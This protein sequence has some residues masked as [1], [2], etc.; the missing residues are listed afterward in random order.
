VHP[1]PNPPGPGGAFTWEDAEDDMKRESIGKEKAIELANSKWW[2]GK[3][4]REIA[5]F[6]M[7]TVEL[8][9]PFDKFHEAIEV[10]LGRGVWT[11]EF[12]LNLNGL[13][14]E[15]FGEELEK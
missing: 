11:H 9:I 1:R 10:A 2:I 7:K 3:S 8:C 5:E 14:K 15:L 6:Q 4:A 12:A 13:F